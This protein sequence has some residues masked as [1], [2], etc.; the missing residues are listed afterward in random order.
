MHLSLFLSRAFAYYCL[1]GLSQSSLST[2]GEEQ[3]LFFCSSPA[4]KKSVFLLANLTSWLDIET[5]CIWV[6]FAISATDC[7]VKLGSLTVASTLISS[8]KVFL[9][10]FVVIITI[11]VPECSIGRQLLK[12]SLYETSRNPGYCATHLRSKLILLA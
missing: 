2:C 7:P 12:F 6:S 11:Q 8:A 10:D 3:Q 1:L 9:R 5:F 4:R